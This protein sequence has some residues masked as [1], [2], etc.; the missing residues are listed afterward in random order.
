MRLRRLKPNPGRLRVVGLVLLSIGLVFLILSTVFP[1]PEGTISSLLSIG[2]GTGKYTAAQPVSTNGM[3]YAQVNKSGCC[4]RNGN[5]QIRLD[6]Y[7]EPDDPRYYD[8]Y[9][10]LVDTDSPEFLAGYPG[11]VDEFGT[12]TNQKQ[13]DTWWASLPRVWVNTPFH[14][15]FIYLPPNFTEEDIKTQIDIHL[16][17]FY[18]AFQDGWDAVQGGMRHGWATETRIRPTDYSKIETPAEYDARVAT[19]EAAIGALTELQ[20][21]PD[22]EI[23]GQTYPSTEIDIGAAATNRPQTGDLGS[24]WVEGS[25]PANDTGTIDYCEIWLAASS[26][27]DV[28]VGTFSASGNILTV[29]D[30][31]SIGAIAA[32]SKQTASALDVDVN[33]ADYWGCHSKSGTASIER[34]L[35]GYTQIWGFAGECIDPSDS[36]TFTPYTGDQ[37]SLWGTGETVEGEPSISNTPNSKGFGILEVGTSATTGFEY[38]TITNNGTVT[39]DVTI[40]GTHATGGIDDVWTLSDTATPDT[41]TYGL[42][43]STDSETLYQNYITGD[44]G[45]IGIAECTWAAQTF[46]PST[47]HTITSVQ[48]LLY[49]SDGSVG[50]VLVSITATSAGKPTGE[51][52]CSGVTDGDTLTTSSSGEWRTITFDAVA[53]LDASTQYALVVSAPDTD[54]AIYVWWRHDISSP[55]YSGGTQVRSWDCGSDWTIYSDT[56]S[57]FKEYGGIFNTIVKYTATYNTLVSDLAINATQDWGLLILMP[58]ALTGYDAQ[59]M[60]ATI[61]LVASAS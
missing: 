60:S 44:D 30:S 45:A 18:Q 43:A 56:D 1:F 6:F 52:L 41:N 12:P 5:C 25:N 20:Y 36:E 19:C 4:V 42:K 57:M 11:K 26:G 49:R 10:Y 34:D 32:G 54:E 50:D 29:R 15:H 28:W 47:S 7:L 17:N 24:T 58:T 13:Y 61:T 33:S 3:A 23:R 40:Q 2:L 38:F 9:L 53:T 51:D 35:V 46:T 21:K 59:Q 14:T 31:E 37:I 55:T 8:K 48:L 39:V 16:G 22:G 27:S